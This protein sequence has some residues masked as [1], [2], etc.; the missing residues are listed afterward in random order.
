VRSSHSQQELAITRVRT[1]VYTQLWQPVRT[2]IIS[3]LPTLSNM[4]VIK[5]KLG[6]VL[7]YCLRVKVISS[8]AARPTPSKH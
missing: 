5:G 3:K 6:Y 4:F 1:Q 7:L 8:K 2:E